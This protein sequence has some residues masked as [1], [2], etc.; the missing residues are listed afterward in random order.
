MKFIN[1][2][3]DTRPLDWLVLILVTTVSVA[4]LFVARAT[5]AKASDLVTVEVKGKIVYRLSLSKDTEVD[6]KGPL[7]ITHVVIKDRRVRVTQSPCPE[8]ICV[9][10]GWISRGAIVCVPNRVVV[11]VGTEIA[12][13]SVD[14]I[15]G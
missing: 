11:T 14:A 1:L 9:R 4:S 13:R 15:T 12:D 3:R 10:Q 2:F 8:K 7:G 5:S 6:V